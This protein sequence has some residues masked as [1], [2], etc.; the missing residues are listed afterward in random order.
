MPRPHRENWGHYRRRH[1]QCD[2][3]GSLHSSDSGAHCNFFRGNNDLNSTVAHG[4]F[5]AYVRLRILG[6]LFCRKKCKIRLLG[7]WKYL[8]ISEL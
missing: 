4:T 7:R 2:G 5:R 3:H 8:D 6:Y 1:L